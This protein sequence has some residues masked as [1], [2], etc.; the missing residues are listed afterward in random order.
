MI[1][2][3]NFFI[4]TKAFFKGCKPPKRK[5]D[6]VSRR[7]NAYWDCDKRW[8]TGSK[9]WYGKDEKGPYIIRQSD[10]WVT[11]KDFDKS[12][13]VKDCESIATCQWHIKTTRHR[14]TMTG[15][16]YLSDFMPIS[17]DR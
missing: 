3:Q 6:Y 14:K 5:P 16:C 17:T 7:K 12:K 4:S 1:T 15:K 9:Y 8:P 13:K 10:H 2:Y 11:V